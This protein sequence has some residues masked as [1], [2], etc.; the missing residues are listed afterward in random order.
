VTRSNSIGS[1][2]DAPPS[3]AGNSSA[4]VK[5]AIVVRQVTWAPPRAVFWVLAL[6][7]HGLWVLRGKPHGACFTAGLRHQALNA[8]TRPPR[9]WR[10]QPA[11]V[12]RKRVRLPPFFGTRP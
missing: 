3:E 7:M 12:N 2:V 11:A 8:R 6:A 1:V 5:M 9:T 10:G 4:P